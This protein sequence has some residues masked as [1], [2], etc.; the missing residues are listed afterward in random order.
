MGKGKTKLIFSIAGFEEIRRNAAAV[1]RIQEEIDRILDAVN[2]NA[3]Y[4]GSVV[5]A[6]GRGTLGRAIG[7]VW[8]TDYKSILDNSRNHSLL[9]A[10]AGQGMVLY[11]S[12][13]GKTS[14]VTQKQANNWSG[15]KGG[16]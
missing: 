11:T 9:R 15:K 7:H 16:G 14:M 3:T 10:L 2:Q 12:K 1:K 4:E 6:P 5:Q 8:T 13:A